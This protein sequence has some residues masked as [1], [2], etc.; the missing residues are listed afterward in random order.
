M[1][2]FDVG[3]VS[4]L[5]KLESSGAER[6]EGRPRH[7]ECYHEDQSRE[8]DGEAAAHLFGA[9]FDPIETNLRERVR[10]FIE[11]IIEAELDAA[12]CRPH[13]GRPAE[14]GSGNIGHRHGH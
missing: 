1:V 7:D 3:V 6:P 10:G 5:P 8:A 14:S 12:L 2:G 13:Y 4:E 11:Q 9:W